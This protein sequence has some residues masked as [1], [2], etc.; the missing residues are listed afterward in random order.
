MAGGAAAVVQFLHALELLD[1]VMH[2]MGHTLH[3]TNLSTP[4]CVIRLQTVFA[5]PS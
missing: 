3:F 4:L 5:D 1:L 2:I